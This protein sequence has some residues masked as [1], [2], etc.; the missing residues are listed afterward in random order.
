LTKNETY[1]GALMSTATFSFVDN[2]SNK[3][4]RCEIEDS[5]SLRWLPTQV[6]TLRTLRALRSFEWKLGFSVCFQWRRNRGSG[7]SMNRGPRAP[8]GPE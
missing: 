1:A 6:L 5:A 2:K 8:G 4:I 7:G 3:C